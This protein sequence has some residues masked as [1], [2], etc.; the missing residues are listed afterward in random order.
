MTIQPINLQNLV[1]T[2]KYLIHYRKKIDL[3]NILMIV[4]F[5]PHP[6]LVTNNKSKVL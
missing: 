3:D 5:Q 6:H 4:I 2:V 1:K